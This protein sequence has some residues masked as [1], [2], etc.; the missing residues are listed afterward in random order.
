MATRSL[1]LAIK[2]AADA[3]ASVQEFAR[4]KKSVA[5]TEKAFEEAQAATA[6]YARQLKAAGGQDT[7]LQRQFERSRKEAR[8][9]KE[10]LSEQ[11]ISLQRQR[12][13][14]RQ[15]GVSVTNLAASWRQLSA[16]Q[17]RAAR[18]SRENARVGAAFQNLDLRPFREIRREIRQ[19]QASYTRLANSGRLSSRELAVAHRRMRSRVR[20]LRQEMRG[21]TAATRGLSSAV[22]GLALAYASLRALQGLIRITDQY[23][24]LEGQLKL[25]TESSEELAQVEAELFDLAQNTRSGYAETVKLYARVARSSKDLGI[26]QNRLLGVTKT[27]NQAIQVSGATAEEASA[28]VVQ[29]SQGLAAGAL[30]GEELNS[31]SEQMPRLLEAIIKGIQEVNPELGITRKNFRDLASEGVLTTELIV[32]ALETQAGTIAQEFSALPR[33]VDQALTQMRN[34]FQ[35]SL[36]DTDMQPLIDSIDELRNVITDPAIVDGLQTL[37]SGSIAALSSVLRFTSQLANTMEFLGEEV[38]ALTGQLAGDDIVRLEERAQL[39]QEM[40]DSSSLSGTRLRFFGKDG[41]VEYYDDQELQGELRKIQQQIDDF[42]NRQGVSSL[43]TGGGAGDDEGAGGE[44]NRLLEEVKREETQIIRDALT[45]QIQAYEQAND[46]IEELQQQRLKIE[47]F[48]ADA[49]DRLNQ[50]TAE[51]DEPDIIDMAG[52]MAQAR[53]ALAAG[54]FEQAIDLSQQATEALQKLKEAGQFEGEL[55]RQQ[56]LGFLA[57]LERIAL[58]AADAEQRAAESTRDRAQQVVAELLGRAQQLRNIEVDFDADA[59]QSNAEILRQQIQQRLNE[60]PVVIPVT[61]QEDKDRDQADKKA[62]ELLENLPARAEGGPIR[63]PGTETSDSILARVSKN[64]YVI[65]AKAVRHYGE[66]FI[67]SINRRRLPKFADGGL[68]GALP[69]I[70]RP[71]PAIDSGTLDNLSG[72]AD[73][74]APVYLYLD[75]RE[76]EMQATPDVSDQLQR[77][78]GREALKRGRRRK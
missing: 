75:G 35:R 54:D 72:Q 9:L 56:S 18:V 59:A 73:S 64:E 61:L 29:F 38:A 2:I 69:S 11:N 65:N 40:L 30:R 43:P 1:S 50:T 52:I 12:D 32:A 36:S 3:K 28:G 24:Q 34:D 77:T 14:L 31:V 49:R 76:F 78:F 37:A 42:Y 21:T 51:G 10:T 19:V 71:A 39:I 23:K 46:R 33:T 26:E 27:I 16:A 4:L 57:Q 58:E 22:G 55:G 5:E 6:D 60:N 74:R 8:R 48:F 7:G 66:Q 62:G 44:R 47:E 63:G 25:V 68:V 15:Q 17:Q 45:E 13:N 20:E 70:P 53:Q 67:S 41:L